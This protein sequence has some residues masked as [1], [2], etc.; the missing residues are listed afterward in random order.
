MYKKK[1]H[2]ICQ[3]HRSSKQ[4]WHTRRMWPNP[5]SLVAACIAW[6]SATN[7]SSSSDSRSIRRTCSCQ[8]KP[9]TNQLAKI[10]QSPFPFPESRRSIVSDDLQGCSPGR[11]GTER[12]CRGRRRG[13]LQRGAVVADADDEDDAKM[14]KTPATSHGNLLPARVRHHQIGL[15]R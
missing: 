15:P 12:R 5:A 10:S 11:V 2:R 7:M 8:P 6:N 9:R 1:V 14:K 4:A 3:L 13:G